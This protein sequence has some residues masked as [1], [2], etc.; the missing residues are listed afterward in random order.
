MRTSDRDPKYHPVLILWP[1]VTTTTCPEIDFAEGST[2][3]STMSFYN[4]YGCAGVQSWGRRVIDTTQWHNYAVE[5][6]PT[7]ITGYVDGVKWFED[8]NPAHQPPGSMHQTIQLDWFPD[9]T[10]TKKSW[11]QVDWVRVY[12]LG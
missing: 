11:M 5:W 1:D 7:S 3:T 2:D 6:T 12:N 4:H 9:G 10:P 8:T